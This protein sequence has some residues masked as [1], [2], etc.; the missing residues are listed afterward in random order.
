MKTCHTD[1]ILVKP[2]L[3][4][5]S[6]LSQQNSSII[7]CSISLVVESLLSSLGPAQQ[8]RPL[9]RPPCLFLPPP[10][11][12]DT[13]RSVAPKLSLHQPSTEHRAHEIC[14]IEKGFT[15]YLRPFCLV[16]PFPHITISF[17]QWKWP[18]GSGRRHHQPALRCLH[19]PS[20]LKR[21]HEYLTEWL[22]V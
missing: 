20:T 18:A 17:H 14:G 19:C 15:V 1:L 22:T 5:K 16:L 7:C 4:G 21:N 2:G 3:L 6:F 12:E 8:L 11:S 10:R 9:P 13:G